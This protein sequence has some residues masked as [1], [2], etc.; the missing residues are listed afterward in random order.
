MNSP[1]EQI[2]QPERVNTL[3]DSDYQILSPAVR[4][5]KKG[6]DYFMF[7][8]SDRTGQMEARLWDA[9]APGA[10]FLKEGAIVRIQG[11]LEEYKGTIQINVKGVN[12]RQSVTDED[13]IRSSKYQIE[14]MWAMLTGFVASIENAWLREV[15]EDLLLNEAWS[16]CFKLSPAAT[17]MHHAFVGGLL[18]HTWQMAE[19]ADSMLKLP[20]MA[21][22]NRDLCLFGV[23][24]HDF[25]KIF[26]YARDKGFARTLQGRL[27]PHI[28]MTAALILEAANKRNV[29]EIV[30]DHM[31][32]VVLAHHG[33]IEYGSPVN[34]NCPEA[35]FIHHIDHMH[36]DIFGWLQRIEVESKPGDETVKIPFGGSEVVVERFSNVLKRLEA[37]TGF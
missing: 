21:P 16:E 12:P 10:Q 20:F 32:H 17:G 3:V 27:V 29:P 30:R 2:R 22:L 9:K 15:A 19:C 26:E 24:L 34:M 11:V 1:I 13:F 23:I 35:V 14:N 25:G 28:P 7:K 4:R 8:I 37:A 6:G 36:G 5:T 18:E 31:M 33:K